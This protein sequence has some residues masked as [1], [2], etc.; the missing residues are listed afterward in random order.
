MLYTIQDASRQ[1]GIPH[2]SLRRLVE[3]HKLGEKTPG[4][5]VILRERE[6]KR[7]LDLRG[8]RGKQ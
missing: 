6:L 8:K 4:G 5:T 7:L 2:M 1:T 3:E